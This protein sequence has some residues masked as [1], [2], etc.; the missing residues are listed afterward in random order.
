MRKSHQREERGIEKKRENM[1]G[2]E[3]KGKRKETQARQKKCG[4]KV[5]EKAVVR[6]WI[7]MTL[8]LPDPDSLVRGTDLDPDPDSSNIKQ[9]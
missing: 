5:E 1:K 2:V 7:R 9:K 6:I 4:W 8:G 3:G